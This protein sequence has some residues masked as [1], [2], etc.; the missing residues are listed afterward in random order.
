MSATGFGSRL[1]HDDRGGA[2]LERTK[3]LAQRRERAGLAGRRSADRHQPQHRRLAP[4]RG[5][6]HRHACTAQA[7]QACQHRL[8]HMVDGRAG[9]R[10]GVAHPVAPRLGQKIERERRNRAAVLLEDAE[11]D[12]G[13]ARRGQFRGESENGHAPISLWRVDIGKRKCLFDQRQVILFL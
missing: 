9:R 12:V 4:D 1:R 11:V 2:L 5:D 6:A 13:P 8:R 7:G 3:Q 10:G